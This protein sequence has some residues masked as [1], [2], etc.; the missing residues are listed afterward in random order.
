M[1]ISICHA[2]NCRQARH[3]PADRQIGSDLEV[4][5]R[6]CSASDCAL[7][8]QDQE[9]ELFFERIEIN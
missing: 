8:A 4:F 1:I 5:V 7:E 9:L 6:S 2:S 3:S